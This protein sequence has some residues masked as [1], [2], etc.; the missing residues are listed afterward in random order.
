MTS[1][2]RNI[3]RA[4]GLL[5][6]GFT[7]HRWN[8]ITKASDADVFFDL[9]PNKRWNKPSRRRSFEKPS[10]LLW[11]HC[12]VLVLNPY[13]LGL[14]QWYGDNRMIGL[15]PEIPVRQSWQI[16][17]QPV[18]KKLNETQQPANPVHTRCYEPHATFWHQD[19]FLQW[20]TKII[21]LKWYN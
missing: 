4:T 8:P 10:R 15:T 3:F 19:H 20:Y 11:H 16:W 6:W 12:N 2:N 5:Q 18:S 14:L 1:S 17:V 21:F 7:G 13:H 9:R